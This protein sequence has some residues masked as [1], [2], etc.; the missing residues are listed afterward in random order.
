MFT[1]IQPTNT[2]PRHLSPS[3][4]AEQ[5]AAA[6]APG[7][8]GYSILY[9]GRPTTGHSTNTKRAGGWLA[10]TEGLKIKA[11]LQGEKCL[12]KFHFIAFF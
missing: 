3:G 1:S 7:A 12:L 6:V 5:V 8:D 11:N 10:D 4:H 2:R 9:G